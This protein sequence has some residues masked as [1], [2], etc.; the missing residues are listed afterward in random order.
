MTYVSYIPDYAYLFSCKKNI[1]TKIYE[2]LLDEDGILWIKVIEGVFI[3]L[4]S[5]IEDDVVNME[6]TGGKKVLVLY[7]SR[8]F[9]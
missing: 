7:D 1:R 4:H 2:K 9:L 6:L 3:D 8:P 5:L